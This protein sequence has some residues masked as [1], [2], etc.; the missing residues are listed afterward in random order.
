MTSYILVFVQ[1]LFMAS[2]VWLI[3]SKT[4]IQSNIYFALTL[5]IGS[6]MLALISEYNQPFTIVNSYLA[7]FTVIE[8]IYLVLKEYLKNH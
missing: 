5:F 8:I 6:V 3:R 2:W 4:T 1:I 7:V